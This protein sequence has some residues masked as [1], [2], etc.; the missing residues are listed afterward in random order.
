MAVDADK[1]VGCGMC[2]RV[3]A[4]HNLEIIDK[5]AQTVLDGCILCGQCAA[6]CP[7]EAVSITSYEGGRLEKNPGVRLNPKEVLE[8]IRFRRSIRRF[9]RRAVPGEVV[10]QILEAGR[11]THT[12]GNM[13]DVSFIVLD[14]EKDRVEQMAVALFRRLKPFAGLFSPMARHNRI[15]DRFFFFNAPIAIV[16]LAKDKTN[17]ILAAQN[18][19]FAAEA[20]GLGVLFSGFFTM[21]ANASH[22]IK[23][24]LGIPRGKR[25][26][27]TLVLGYPDVTFLRCAPRKELDVK[28]L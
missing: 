19:E 12:A 6:V 17:G 24:A 16:V 21:A 18:M 27:M 23:K 2:A 11:L 25:V 28:Y 26:A 7:K 22:R 13:Q 9:Q 1:C 20:N 15:D 3:C 8:V 4:A 5:K 10:R 14:R